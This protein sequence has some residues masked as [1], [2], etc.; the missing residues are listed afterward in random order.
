VNEVSAFAPPEWGSLL[1]DILRLS[2]AV[3]QQL[4]AAL[5]PEGLS[6]PKLAMLRNLVEAGDPVPLGVLSARLGCVKSNVTQ[7]ID[8]LE[9]DRLVQRL[10]DPDD[11]RSKLAAITEA[12]R[13]RYEAGRRAVAGAEQRILASFSEADRDLLTQMLQR[14]RQI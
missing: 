2:H 4:D 11:R 3:E 14:F 9:A 12:G 5:Q 8:R 7:L 10:P 13:L 6:L 1:T